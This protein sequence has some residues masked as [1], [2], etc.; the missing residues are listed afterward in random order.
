MNRKI[1]NVVSANRVPDWG[2]KKKYIAVHY[3]GVVGQNHD[4]SSDGSGAHF[5]IYW[6]GTIY[7]RCSLNAVPWAVGTAGYY[8]QKH[9]KANNYNT[10][11]IEMCC[12]CDGN[13]QSAEDPK[14]YFTKETQEA[15]VWLVQKLMKE[16]G[17]PAENVLRHFDIVNKT[18]PAPYVHNNKYRGTWT[19]EEF[20]RRISGQQNTSGTQTSEFAGLSETAAAA[21]LL[22]ICRPI[23]E[24]SDLFP[25]VCAAQTILE[26]GYC[27]TEL[28]KKANNVCGMKCMLSGNTW[29]G[30]T[31]DEKSKVTIRTAE[32]DSNGNVY[33]VNADFRAYPC[34]E[35]S[36]ADRCAYLLGAKNGSQ[37]RYDGIQECQNYREQ[38]ELIKAGGYAT[39]VAYVNKIC[40]IIERFDL[41]KYDRVVNTPKEVWYRVRKTWG[42]TMNGQI[43]AYHDLE[44]AKEVA[45]ANPGYSVYDESGNVIYPK[46]LT[47]NDLLD[48]LADFQEQ[49]QKD[50]AAGRK[51]IYSNSGC[52]IKM[53]TA[54]KKGNRKCN[55]ALLVRWA[56]RKLGLLNDD[57]WW[58]E[59]GG[60][61]VWKGT[62]KQQMLKYFDLLHVSGKKT[63]NQ[64]IKDGTLQSG[65]IVT[66][67]NMQH[68]NVYAGNGKWFDAG[69]AYCKGTGEGA[70]FKSWYGDT[71]HGSQPIGYILRRKESEQPEE[72]LHIVR[73]GMY[74]KKA[75]ADRRCAEIN[76]AGIDCIVKRVGDMWWTQCGAFKNLENAKERVWQL[77]ASGFDGMIK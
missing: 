72:K 74:I 62:S 56:L 28:A 70:V 71:V 47:G 32:Q 44:K 6:D 1:I 31:W 64:A 14:W 60:K 24:K 68:T 48:T 66:Y 67:V 13:A 55:C 29:S 33:Y 12:K 7:Q 61:I 18:C 3:L 73:E 23:A 25:S 77:R 40:N 69:H 15:C 21:R 65:D 42:T 20:R 59:K 35:D 46:K 5:Y 45:D 63:V 30:S 17:I 43:G 2:N 49:L 4:L 51:W 16:N 57:N 38:I 37:L 53:S 75:N 41:A 26:S 11:S 76:N 8:T 39:D 10:I 54:L 27:T 19:W 50:I 34:I 22:E 9:P 36:I 52:S 58:G